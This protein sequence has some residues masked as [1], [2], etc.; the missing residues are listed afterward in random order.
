MGHSWDGL[1]TFV[2]FFSLKKCI[3]EILVDS[4]SLLPHYSSYYCCFCQSFQYSKCLILLC[5]GI[6]V[7][8][9]KLAEFL[10]VQA[11]FC[12]CIHQ[13]SCGSDG[14]YACFYSHFYFSDL[15]VF[16]ILFEVFDV[17]DDDPLSGSFRG[18]VDVL[19][20]AIEIDA[21]FFE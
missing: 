12:L 17:F 21:Y 14:L 18:V 10:R 9:E 11:G 16:R 7:F 8:G 5:D 20:E 15:E 19:Y 6:V 4:A 2:C 3:D 13:F 1:W